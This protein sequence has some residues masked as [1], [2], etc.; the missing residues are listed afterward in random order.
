MPLS[1]R[2]YDDGCWLKWRNHQPRPPHQCLRMLKPQSVCDNLESTETSPGFQQFIIAF[3]RLLTLSEGYCYTLCDNFGCFLWYKKAPTMST[4]G[5]NRS[6]RPLNA[7]H[8]GVPPPISVPTKNAP[9]EPG[10]K[11]SI[12]HRLNTGG[13]VQALTILDNEC[14][15]AGLQGGKILV[16][17]CPSLTSAEH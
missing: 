3:I 2:Y 16:S 15:I 5:R 4:H 17:C 8:L 10:L 11:M 7:P 9:P 14:L 13:S 1:E 12:T 6:R